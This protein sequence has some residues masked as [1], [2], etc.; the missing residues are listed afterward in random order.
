MCLIFF[1]R[2]HIFSIEKKSIEFTKIV[3]QIVPN[4]IEYEVW[5]SFYKKT[6]SY[7]FSNY[8]WKKGTPPTYSSFIIL[9][10]KMAQ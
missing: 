8:A 5:C 1:P 10:S 9:F 2:S 6:G 3:H 4:S 7:V